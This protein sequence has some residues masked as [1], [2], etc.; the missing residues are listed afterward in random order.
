MPNVIGSAAFTSLGPLD[1]EIV[2]D[3]AALNDLS[4]NMSTI[5]DRLADV[6]AR[7]ALLRDNLT[8]FWAG[9]SFDAFAGVA[10]QHAEAI[11]PLSTFARDTSSV[12]DAYGGLI[13]RGRKYFDS[14]QA[15]ATAASLTVSESRFILPP[16]PGDLAS[17][18]TD[19]SDAETRAMYRYQVKVFT[20][21]SD[22]VST[23][24]AD[25]EAWIDEYF[26][27][28][29]GR[30]SELDAI[31]SL[32]IQLRDAGLATFDALVDESDKRVE[33]GLARF[34]EQQQ[35]HEDRWQEHKKDT[36][37]GD[38]AREARGKIYD[39]DAH[40]AARNTVDAEIKKLGV[41]DFLTKGG[42]AT[43]ALGTIAAA[44]YD[45]SQG[46]S[47]SNVAAGVTGGAAG[48]GLGLVVGAALGTLLWP[49]VGTAALGI[50]GSIVGSSKGSDAGVWAWETSTSLR[51]RQAIDEGI[52][53]NYQ[54]SPYL[55]PNSITYRE[56]YGAYRK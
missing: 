14:Y 16:S 50:V 24:R 52:S 53:G 56:G 6:A 32:I 9:K 25:H 10:Q 3:V 27:P 21:I 22:L 13:E 35:E 15:V 55:D 23:W 46:Q 36:R 33:K 19:G 45:L 44:G 51:T 38:P 1:L 47:P 30:T 2:G 20:E 48:G 7:V 29:L 18:S 8:F 17:C 39:E 37:S 11:T 40:R 5:A 26:G 41:A 42:K 49:G 31:E 54:I 34:L 43:G 4:R 12:V 28:L